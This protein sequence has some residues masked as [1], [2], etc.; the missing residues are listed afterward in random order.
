MIQFMRREKK[1]SFLQH[2]YVDDLLT[3]SGKSDLKEDFTYINTKLTKR[4]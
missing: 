2:T 4:A 3:S 1:A